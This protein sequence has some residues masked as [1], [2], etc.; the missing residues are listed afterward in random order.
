MSLGYAVHGYAWTGK[1]T[2]ES[3]GLI[4]WASESGFDLIA[5]PLVDLD[6]IDPRKVRG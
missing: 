1:W 5:I 4:D 3:L 2:D 6:F